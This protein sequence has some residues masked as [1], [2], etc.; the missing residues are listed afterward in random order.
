MNFVRFPTDV[1]NVSAIFQEAL[2]MFQGCF[3]NVSGKFLIDFIISGDLGV[4]LGKVL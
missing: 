1:G 3:G 2:G 4:N